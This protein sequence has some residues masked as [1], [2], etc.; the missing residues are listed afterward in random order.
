MQEY[1]VKVNDRGQIVIPK[2]VRDQFGIRSS[3][4]MLVTDDGITLSPTTLLDEFDDL[5]VKD[6][7]AKGISSEQFEEKLLERKKQ[8]TKLYLEELDARRSE[9][10][11]GR[12]LDEIVKELGL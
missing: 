10:S 8:I 12:S 9:D 1:M 7:N 2:Q 4:R 3:L 5:I 6:L 11:Q